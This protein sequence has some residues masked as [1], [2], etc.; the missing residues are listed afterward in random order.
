MALPAGLEGIGNDHAVLPR[1][2][3]VCQGSCPLTR[4]YAVVVE[5]AGQEAALRYW[6]V[7]LR[8][9]VRGGIFGIDA[10][11]KVS[12][13]W[14][15]WGSSGRR[16]RGR[17]SASSAALGDRSSVATFRSVPWGAPGRDHVAVD[18]VDHSEQRMRQLGADLSAIVTIVPEVACGVFP[19]ETPAEFA[20]RPRAEDGIVCRLE[21]VVHDQPAIVDQAIPMDRVEDVRIDIH[22]VCC[23]EYPAR[24]QL[25]AHVVRARAEILH[26]AAAHLPGLRRHHAVLL[27][28]C[29]RG[30]ILGRD[31]L[32]GAQVGMVLEDQR[33]QSLPVVL[34]DAKQPVALVDLHIHDLQDVVDL[35]LDLIALIEGVD[36]Q[37]LGVVLQSRR[38]DKD[39]LR[40]RHLA[41]Q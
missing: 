24:K 15:S 30:G 27:R 2:A 18:W 4:V 16:G 40:G 37:L 29:S 14:A 11:K 10:F 7:E 22:S 38:Q 31:L 34:L 26:D 20:Q 25:L 17:C 6:H 23:D 19:L 1:L 12:I 39:D 8:Q 13:S 3:L 5:V 36:G 41:H 32:E 28:S 35:M 33:L 9:Q 21:I